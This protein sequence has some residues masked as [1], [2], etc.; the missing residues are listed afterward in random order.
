MLRA[1]ARLAVDH[2]FTHFEGVG[3]LP[4]FNPDLDREEGPVPAEVVQL[5]KSVVAADL[6]LISTPE[7]A[8]GLPGAFKNVL[9]WLVSEPGFDGKPV[10][11]L[12]A[13]R[14]SKW[15]FDSLKEI[16]RTMS[17]IV[18]D[19]ACAFL[20]LGSNRIDE[21]AILSDANLRRLLETSIQALGL[22]SQR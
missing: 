12:S 18:I 9:D 5:R 6:L 15:A 19:D 3:D 17:A 1:F 4:H 14:G 21:E 20:P 16:L 10:A 2:A 13:E 8:H 11:I 22:R 7:Y